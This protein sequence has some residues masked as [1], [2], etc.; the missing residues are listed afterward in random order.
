MTFN[1]F[2]EWIRNFQTLSPNSTI[3]LCFWIFGLI[4]NILYVVILSAAIDIVDTDIPKSL[5]LLVDILPSLT[6]KL[7]SPFFIQRIRYGYRIIL[8][9]I[10]SCVGMIL[11]SLKDLWICLLGVGLASLSSGFGEVTFLQLTHMYKEIS[12]NGWSS[13]TG[14]AGLF[15]S[16]VYWLVTTVLHIPIHI[17]LLLFSILPFGFLLYFRL[18]TYV[19]YQALPNPEITTIDIEAPELEPELGVFIGDH[20]NEESISSHVL[21]TLAKLKVLVVPYMLPLTTVYFF[22]YLINQAVSPTLLFPIA[23][24]DENSMSHLSLFHKYRDYY[25]TYSIL[26]QIG[27]FISRSTAHSFRVKKLYILSFLQAINLF[28]VLLQSTNYIVHQPWS[29]M[30]LIVYEGLLGGSSYVNTF[31]NVLS[32]VRP[33]DREFALGSVSIADSLGILLAALVGMKLEPT[34]CQHQINNNRPWCTLD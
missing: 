26:Y 33:Q 29:I 8:L 21:E 32:N 12:L 28:I 24:P 20:S 22:E 34:L 19:E 18:G 11:V 15:G 4:N 16:A 13:G 14:G 9:I 1:K 23:T 2:S 5:V 31:L 27:V 30:V 7:L 6:I 3:Y 17:S 25:V 10:L